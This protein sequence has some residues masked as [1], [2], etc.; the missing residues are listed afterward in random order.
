MLQRTQRKEVMIIQEETHNYWRDEKKSGEKCKKDYLS[1]SFDAH[2]L[3][4]PHGKTQCTSGP[5]EERWQ[6]N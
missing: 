2:S 1:S 3:C 4:E 6:V 5:N